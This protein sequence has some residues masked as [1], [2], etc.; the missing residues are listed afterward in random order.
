MSDV[1]TAETWI[2]IG[3]AVV[4]FWGTASWALV[5]TLRQEDRKVRLI[6]SQGGMESYSPRALSELREWIQNNPD[7]PRVEDAR[8]AYNETVESLRTIE[9]PY[10]DW[11]DAE[12]DSLE[13]I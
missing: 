3:V 11:D 6:E 1:I 7:D 8:A 4:A 5:R 10:Y 12:I 13:R 2:G 9:E